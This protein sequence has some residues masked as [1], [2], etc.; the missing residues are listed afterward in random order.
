MISAILIH[1]KTQSLK[2]QRFK[3]SGWKDI[4]IRKLV[5]YSLRQVF[6]SFQGRVLVDLISLLYYSFSNHFLTP[7]PV[8]S[9]TLPSSPY[10]QFAKIISSPCRRIACHW[11]VKQF[12]TH[13]SCMTSYLS[14]LKKT[15]IFDKF[16]DF[17][18]EEYS[19]NTI[20]LLILHFWFS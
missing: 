12:H 18:I 5:F 4:R 13:Y 14:N 20:L 7:P 3:P 6:S 15:C 2:Y 16:Q 11:Y 19:I 8:I 9:P 10:K 1:V 17:P